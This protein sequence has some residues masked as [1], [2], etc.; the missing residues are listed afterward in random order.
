MKS[1]FKP[2]KKLIKSTAVAETVQSTAGIEETPAIPAVLNIESPEMKKT[3]NKMEEKK[4]ENKP[5]WGP[6]IEKV[7]ES[8]DSST[9]P[10]V[11]TPSTPVAPTKYMPPSAR[12]GED[13]IRPSSSVKLSSMPTLA[14]SVKELERAKSVN[15]TSQQPTKSKD[16]DEV[17]RKEKGKEERKRQLQEEL[18][19]IGRASCRERV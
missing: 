19:Q 17:A 6:S 12:R 5:T 3:E 2:K 1:L 8:K 16:T 4:T 10:V 15:V 13:S 7:E 11:L 18:N 9:G 14:E